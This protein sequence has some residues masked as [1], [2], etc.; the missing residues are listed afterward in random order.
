M[1]GNGGGVAMPL[2]V[3]LGNPGARYRDTPHNIGFEIVAR[4]AERAQAT[5][6]RTQGGKAEEA[7]W[8]LRPRVIL[9]RPL[10]YM[11]LS[12]AVVQAGLGRHH[13]ELGELLVVCDDVNL[14]L[15]HLRF[16][17]KGGAGGQKGLLSIIDVLGT[18]EFARLRVGVGGGEPGADVAR[19][20]LRKFAR[21]LRPAMSAA[22]NR[23]ADAAE[24]YLSDGLEAA[25]NR[26]NT[27]R[28]SAEDD[29]PSGGR[30]PPDNLSP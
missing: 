17:M 30:V 23:A 25:M 6:R 21:D 20:V 1:G 8:P 12:G 2:I 22:V 18:E 28:S 4:L 14:P 19:Y 27:R 26:F 29:N 15:G 3:G 13:F 11:N 9:L 5:F 16:R 10:S 7:A 24:C